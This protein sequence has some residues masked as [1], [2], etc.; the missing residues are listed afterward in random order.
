M[1]LVNIPDPGW[2]WGVGGVGWGGGWWAD[3]SSPTENEH[4]RPGVGV[5]GADSSSPTENAKCQLARCGNSRDEDIRHAP[6]RIS[7]A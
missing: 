1:T 3:G 4:S 5:G 6:V 2:G 7:T